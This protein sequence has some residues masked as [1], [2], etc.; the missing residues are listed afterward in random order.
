VCKFVLPVV[1]L[2]GSVVDAPQDNPPR[3][4]ALCGVCAVWLGFEEFR[5][6]QGLC[7]NFSDG[8]RE[9]IRALQK[10]LDIAKKHL[11]EALRVKPSAEHLEEIHEFLERVP[12]FREFARLRFA[13]LPTKIIDLSAKLTGGEFVDPSEIEKANN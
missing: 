3:V 7:F 12:N 2:C 4:Y 1:C 10:E 11:E 13:L 5:F 6:P 9:K 8:Q